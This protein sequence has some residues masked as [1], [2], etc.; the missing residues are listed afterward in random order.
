MY[1]RKKVLICPLSW[2]L[3]HATR[4]VLIIRKLIEHDFEV[5]IGA[6]GYSLEFLRKEFPLLKFYNISGYSVRYSK[7]TTQLI[8]M[9]LLIPR[10]LIWTIKEHYIL[11]KLVKD[12]KI[13]IIISDNRFGLWNRNSY[14]IFVTHQLRVKFPGILKIFEIIF[15]GLSSFFI[16]NYDECWIP[17][18]KEELNLSG[19]LSHLKKIP[20]NV[21]FVGPLS[22][23]EY[24]Q[25]NNCEKSIDVLFMLSGPEPQRSIFEN[26]IYRQTKNSSLRCEIVRGTL[27]ERENK[28]K[29]PVYDISESNKLHELI[30]KSE[31]VVCRSGYSSVM[32]LFSIG[33]KAVLVP[34]P[35]QTEQEYLAK[36]LSQKKYFYSVS[37]KE[38]NIEEDIKQVYD[39]IKIT[40]KEKSKLEERILCLKE[41]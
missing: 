14:S 37:Q 26:I 11:S 5:V 25:T 30:S 6:S 15:Q 10:I 17:D 13:D 4:D 9:L 29:F 21:I 24:L 23:F 27:T 28:F 39:S 38:F 16:K 41:R 19:G 2:G 33:K 40:I 1:K 35:G 32:D 12:H 3:G 20:K 36:Y 34:T 7:S 8:K 18:F 31:M 22:R